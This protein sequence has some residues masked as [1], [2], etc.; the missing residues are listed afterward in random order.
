VRFDVGTRA[1]EGPPAV[2]LRLLGTR[3]FDA[4]HNV[5]ARYAFDRTL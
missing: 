4:S 2:A 5:L 1:F 3:S